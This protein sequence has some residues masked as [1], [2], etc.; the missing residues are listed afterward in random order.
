[1]TGND[2]KVE[3]WGLDAILDAAYEGALWCV[4]IFCLFIFF[5]VDKVDVTMPRYPGGAYQENWHMNRLFQLAFHY[6]PAQ[7][8][9][10]IVM[11]MMLASTM[12]QLRY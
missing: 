4:F 3:I 9:M 1:M 6:G 11:I 2:V 8:I 5:C 10:M 7:V 12:V